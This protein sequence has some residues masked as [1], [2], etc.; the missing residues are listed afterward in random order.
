VNQ[1]VVMSHQDSNQRAK[2]EDY[3]KIQQLQ[4]QTQQ[5]MSQVDTTSKTR[6][7]QPSIFPFLFCSKNWLAHFHTL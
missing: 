1:V 7:N 3:N 2:V 5:E 6:I 4:Q